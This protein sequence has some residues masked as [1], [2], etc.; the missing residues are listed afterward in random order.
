MT[1][2][3]SVQDGGISDMGPM[4]A[5]ALAELSRLALAGA[6]R[7]DIAACGARWLERLVPGCLAMVVEPR[8]DCGEGSVLAWSGSGT[9]LA[10]ADLSFSEGS[11]FGQALSQ[12]SQVLWATGPSVGRAL[13]GRVASL[14]AGSVLV[15]AGIAA[16]QGGRSVLAVLGDS[17]LLPRADLVN[18]ALR[19]LA[20]QLALACSVGRSRAAAAGAHEAISKA[21]L[22]WEGTADALVDVVC[23]L[24]HHGRI[25]RANRAVEHWGLGPV[26]ES[27]G[28]TP[29]ELFHDGC[30]VPNCSLAS[31][32]DTG[33]K[34]LHQSQPALFEFDDA[35]RDRVLELSFRALQPTSEVVQSVRDSMAVLV[36]S[37]VTEL[38]KAREALNR[39]NM[40]LELKVRTRT[41]ELREANSGLRNEVARRKAAEIALRASHNELGILSEQLIAA[42][43]NERHRI[44]RELHD[45]VGQS[46]IACKYSMERAAE[47]LRRP[48]LGDPWPV[49]MQAIRGAQETSDSIRTIATS[50]RP[51]ILDDMGAASAVS[52]FCRQFAEV[53]PMLTVT[54]QVEATDV[55]VPD[56][57]ATAVFR[58]AQELLNN[59]AKHAAATNV[60]V[61][62]H[63]EPMALVLEVRDNGRGILATAAGMRPAHGHGLRNLRERAEMT[64]G[65][66]T[67]IPDPAG[68]TFAQL[69][70]SLSQD[71]IARLREEKP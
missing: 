2:R 49:L 33:W 54:T 59:V 22:E 21:K 64:G 4:A 15:A 20:S 50:L 62:L 31:A 48:S 51:P 11:V 23:L 70:W 35:D 40:N 18:L 57:L 60:D 52:W 38:R 43:E 34:A 6:D 19:I 27:L 28:R 26:G 25:V 61:G 56:R 29:H 37:N 46:L 30:N 7:K 66:F 32:I 55:E 5:D 69:A 13:P 44:A 67:I 12:P 8:H 3:S 41:Q 36:V 68:G 53:Y 10:G 71:D 9:P 42:Q 17:A 14:V 24:D 16:K 65:V 58:G 45:G 63:R 47:M 1:V 39:L